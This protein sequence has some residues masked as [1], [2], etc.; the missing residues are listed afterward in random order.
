MTEL[1][2]KMPS[3]V[4]NLSMVFVIKWAASVFQIIGYAATAYGATP[5]NI[6]CFLIGLVGWLAV[7]IM[8]KD[9][10]IILIHV[11]ALGSMLMGI[12]GQA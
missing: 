5:L 6:Y 11:I 2:Q 12:L 4:G 10:A 1:T 3:F 8:W 9:R 7:G